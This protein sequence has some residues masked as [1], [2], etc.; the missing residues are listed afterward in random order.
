MHASIRAESAVQMILLTFL[1]GSTELKV[2]ARGS[3][4]MPKGLT[5]T[6]SKRRKSTETEVL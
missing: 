1:A 5:G 4:K 2:T 6:A 3:V